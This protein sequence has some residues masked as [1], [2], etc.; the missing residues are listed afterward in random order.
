ML[1]D[2]TV[3]LSTLL[4][5]VSFNNDSKDQSD[6]SVG[7]KV[8]LSVSWRSTTTSADSSSRLGSTFSRLRHRVAQV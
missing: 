6:F 1:L 8:I 4:P 3:I 2:L 5:V 7:L